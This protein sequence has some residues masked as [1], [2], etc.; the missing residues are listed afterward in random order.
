MRNPSV[1]G[2]MRQHDGMSP[3]N[4]D[5]RVEDLSFSHQTNAPYVD[6]T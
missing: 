6:D 1:M 2:L 4:E 3:K 5:G